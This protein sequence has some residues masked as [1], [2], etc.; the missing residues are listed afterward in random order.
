VQVTAQLAADCDRAGVIHTLGDDGAEGA[1]DRRLR[2]RFGRAP[3]DVAAVVMRG[4]EPGLPGP[5]FH[6][7]ADER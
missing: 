4:R 2:T 1:R 6:E 5:A 3:A 7:H